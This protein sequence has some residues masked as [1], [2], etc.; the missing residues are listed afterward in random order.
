MQPTPCH[1]LWDPHPCGCSLQESPAENL[2][3]DVLS[4]PFSPDEVLGQ[5]RRTKR[6]APGVDGITYS[7]WRWVDP[8]GSILAAIFNTCRLNRKIPTTWKHST[9]T[10]I[11]KGGDVAIIRNWRTI[12]LQLTIYKTYSALIA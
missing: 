9:V 1:P 6:S 5:V 10:L 3:G 7:D 12:S 11:H 2:E 8:L 4:E